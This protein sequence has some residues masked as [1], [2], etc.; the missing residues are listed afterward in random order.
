MK[1]SLP[2]IMPIFRSALFIT[3]GLLF[4]AITNQSLNESIKWWPVL[5]IIFN[6]ITILILVI[7]CKLEG[8]DY[9]D[10]INYKKGHL[11][12]KSTLLIIML[13]LLI[14]VGGLFAFGLAIYGYVPTILIQPI[15]IWI[16][17]INTILLPVTIVFAEL[18]LY[19]GYSFNRIKD[20]T[21]SKF[22]AM[23]YIVFFY[24]LQ[25]SFIPLLFD[26]QYMLFRFLSFLPL[27]IVLGINYNKKRALAPLM[28]GHGFLDLATGVQILISSLFPAIF[29]IMQHSVLI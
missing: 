23:S 19:Y 8:F 9:W 1:K 17:L 6:A 18:P 2:Y 3:G 15:P 27:I 12:L 14:G 21:G 13:M 10:L 29:E 11:N 5:C 28:I 22:L 4:A 24:A 25:H 26:W 20:K 16:A 7:V